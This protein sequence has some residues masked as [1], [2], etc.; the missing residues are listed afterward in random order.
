MKPRLKLPKLVRK[1][2]PCLRCRR[3]WFTDAAHRICKG[4]TEYN[5]AHPQTLHMISAPTQQHGT[6]EI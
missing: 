2:L 6:R 1:F 4:C 3:P 5:D